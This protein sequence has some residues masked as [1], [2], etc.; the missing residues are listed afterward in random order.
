M[1]LYCPALV[2]IL[3]SEKYGSSVGTA[4]IMCDVFS[5]IVTFVL[6]L[7]PCI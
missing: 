6:I 3:K 5:V 1:G 4:V 2:I 7:A